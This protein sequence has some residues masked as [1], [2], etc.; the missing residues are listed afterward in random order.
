MAAFTYEGVILFGIV[1]F[2]AYVY[3]TLTQQRHALQGQTGLQITLFILIGVYFVWFWTRGGQTVADKTWRIRVVDG[4]GRAL[5]PL[6]AAARYVTSYIWF[7]PALVTAW[8]IGPIRPLAVGGLV[9]LGVVVYAML[10]RLHP[11]RQF[12][13][14]VLCGTQLIDV[15]PFDAE[16][17]A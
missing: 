6:R 1:M 2:A 16:R 17:P 10:A 3:G 4:H 8:W 9:S 13:H 12:V 7:A 11:R 14:D 15:K 5:T